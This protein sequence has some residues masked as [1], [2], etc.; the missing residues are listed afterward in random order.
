MSPRALAP[1][2]LVVA[3]INAAAVASRFDLLAAKLPGGAALAV[4][5]AVV[6]LLFLAGYFE[7]RLDYGEQMSSLPLWMR[8]KSVPVKLAFTFGFMYLT[9]VALQTWNVSI[10]PVDPSPPATFPP[11]TRAMWF[12]IFTAGMFFP[13]YLAA[14]SFLIPL[15]RFL[16]RPLRALPGVAGGLVV[17]LVGGALGLVVMSAVTSSKLGAF[18]QGI[19]AAIGANPAI[20]IGVTLVT[21]LGP[22]LL[23]L[24][25]DRD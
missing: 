6:P 21:T 17:L 9:C 19:K 22:M 3:L 14:T 16:T 24:V 7:G 25:L 2:F 20:A 8:I 18:I 12:G 23:G 13:F 15:L 10:G 4:M 5:L 1:F 11:G